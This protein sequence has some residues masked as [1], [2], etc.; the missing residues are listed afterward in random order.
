MVNSLF[1]EEEARWVSHP[2]TIRLMGFF[3]CLELL[4]VLVNDKDAVSHV[5]QGDELITARSR[6]DDQW[7]AAQTF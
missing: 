3:V 7:L 6:F 4:H 5:Q 2:S 1:R